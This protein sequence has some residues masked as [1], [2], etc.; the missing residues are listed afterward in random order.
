MTITPTL[1]SQS[2]PWRYKYLKKV[3]NK[4]LRLK[5]QI[6]QTPESEETAWH[7]SFPVQNTSIFVF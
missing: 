5:I 3:K 4:Q 2:N 6:L 1:P 7:K